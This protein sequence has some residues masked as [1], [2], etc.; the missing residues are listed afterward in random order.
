MEL[1]TDIDRKFCQYDLENP[2]IWEAFKELTLT[3]I[4]R[5]FEKISAE[6]V[7]NQIRWLMYIQHG[8]D[9]FKIN[10]NFKPFYA[11]KFA[12]IYPQHNGIF[13]FRKSKWDLIK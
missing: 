3:L 7:Y 5:G 12:R 13:A 6:L 10:N 2:H 1:F 4:D 11:R 9:G 8:N